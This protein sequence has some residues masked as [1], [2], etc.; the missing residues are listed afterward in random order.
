[1][2]KKRRNMH[3]GAKASTFINAFLLR[4]NPT[5]AEMLLWDRLKD[6]QIERARFR[7]Q[8][9]M[10]NFVVDN[11]C[12]ELKLSIEIDGEYHNEQSQKFYDDDR[13]EILVEN[14]IT[15]IRFTNEQIYHSMDSVLEEIRKTIIS[16][17]ERKVK[18][19]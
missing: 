3:L 14:K 5:E 15:L 18:Q 4:K 8:H 10:K 19:K 9:P 7:R 11:F 1:M 16:M 13:T 17:R 2:A 12:N 6:R